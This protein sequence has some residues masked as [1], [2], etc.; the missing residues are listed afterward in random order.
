[1][2]ESTATKYTLITQLR[3]GSNTKYRLKLGN[4]QEFT[5]IWV[6]RGVCVLRHGIL[7]DFFRTIYFAGLGQHPPECLKRA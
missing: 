3:V 4:K 1:M 7:A 5:K 6:Q 2:I